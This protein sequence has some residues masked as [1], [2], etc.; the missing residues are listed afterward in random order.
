M[1]AHTIPFLSHRFETAV[2]ETRGLP[3]ARVPG[4]L[5]QESASTLDHVLRGLLRQK[6]AGLGDASSVLLL[7][8]EASLWSFRTCEEALI[9]SGERMG[10][11][12]LQKSTKNI[13]LLKSIR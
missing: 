10:K 12:M 7:Q 13:D 6:P 2:E 9:D 5:E 3:I 11:K 4:R 8:G 1:E